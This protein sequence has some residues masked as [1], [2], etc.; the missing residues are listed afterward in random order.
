MK[1]KQTTTDTNTLESET[2]KAIISGKYRDCYL[3]YNR[4]ST[5][6]PENQKNS[7]HYQKSENARFAYREHLK[8]APVSL[9][10][11][12]AEGII[13]ERHS[14]FK[15]DSELTFGADGMIQYRI[16]RPKFY[17]LVGFLNKGYF[18]GVIVLCWDRI[19]RN[20]G[21]NNIINKLIM[22]GADFRFTLASY[23]KTSAGALHMDIDGMFAEHNSRVTREKVTLNIRNKREQ[24][25]CT[26]KAPVG[27]L[28]PGQMEHK[29]IDPE[30]GP[31]IAKLF[32][33]YATGEWSMSALARWATD[34]GFTMPPTRRRRTLEERLAEEENDILMVIEPICR[35]PTVSSLQHI[36][37]N[38]FYLGEIKGNEGKFVQSNSH[39]ALVGKALFD[40]VQQLLQKKNISIHY[41]QSLDYP[42]RGMVRCVGCNRLYT[43]Y[44]KKG[45]TYYGCHCSKECTN[46]IKSINLDA[47]SNKVGSHIKGLS[48]TD[49]EKAEID[50]RATTD[51]PKVKS[52]FQ[53]EIDIVDRKKKK[54]REDLAYLLDNKLTLLKAGVY[55]PET[56]V[57]EEESL[58][59]Q[60]RVMEDTALP[61]A[62]E[63]S[64]N[65]SN[66]LNLSELLNNLYFYYEKANPD[67]REK[68]TRILFSELTLSENS[69]KYKCTE[70]FKVFENRF[71]V[72]CA[73]D[74]WLS[75]L[76]HHASYIKDAINEIQAM[77]DLS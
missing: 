10:G 39:Q 30:R 13:A 23:D 61:S 44:S 18:K 8:I 69:L 33:L 28:N 50:S 34:Q 62:E 70:G 36:L 15:E 72:S 71:I 55:T 51:I 40:K 66:L 48:F 58:N 38:R 73:P 76:S 68:I 67:E 9:P 11:F 54:L 29:P 35:P 41:T 1:E 7:L 57:A 56:F 6:E 77:M 74:S 49:A 75:E 37:T 22:Q 53:K 64:E 12:C 31:F 27:Y 2:W 25:I 42:M 21:D 5:D 45:I 14:G 19:S 20:K 59:K 60:L 46:P 47:L 32:E 43:P 65:V 26:H 16:E 24:G 4:K 17:Q 52:N 3:I 63:I